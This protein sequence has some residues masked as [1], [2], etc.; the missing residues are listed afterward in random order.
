MSHS[1]RGAGRVI[2]AGGPRAAAWALAALL[3]AASPW[4]AAASEQPAED[5]Q[6]QEAQEQAAEAEE[7]GAEEAVYQPPNLGAPGDRVGAST[8]AAGGGPLVLLAPPGGGYSRAESPELHWWLREPMAGTWIFT[9][10]EHD[11]DQ[12][13]LV[14]EQD[15]DG[16]SG[17]RRLALSEYGL[18]LAPEQIYRW[19]LAILPTRGGAP[20]R[21]SSYVEQRD[22]GEPGDGSARALAAAGY[23]YDALS[24]LTAK[25]ESDLAGRLA[26]LGVSVE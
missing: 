7:D 26:R 4:P 20:I 15:L 16:G 10:S 23:W 12:P 21:A 11:S 1:K 6:A 2:P 13:L 17:L 3:A 19:T 9:L 5:S 14:V 8:R 25:D 18:R 22:L 24:A